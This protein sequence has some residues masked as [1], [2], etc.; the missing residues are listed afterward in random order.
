MLGL[1]GKPEI[2]SCVSSVMHIKWTNNLSDAEKQQL[3]GWG[4]DIFQSE[5]LNLIWRPKQVHLVLYQGSIP[6]SKCGLVRQT[7]SVGGRS[8]SIGGIGGVVTQPP[9][10]GQGHARALLNEALAILATEHHQAALLFCRA[11]L[12]P[13]YQRQGWREIH[14]SVTVLQPDGPILFPATTMVYLLN[15]QPSWPKGPVVIDSPPW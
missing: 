9:Y 1:P 3:L 12:I 15:N 8:F 10:Q 14:E 7:I 4:E 11:T 6:L 2:S 5:G 13:Y